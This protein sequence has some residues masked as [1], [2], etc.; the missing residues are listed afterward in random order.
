MFSRTLL[1]ILIDP[2]K[3][4]VWIVL[5]HPPIYNS[6]SPLTMLM[7]LFQVHLLQL[8]SLSPACTLAFLVLW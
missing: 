6:S 5:T 2:N 7:G 3:A 1:G 4:V 8:A